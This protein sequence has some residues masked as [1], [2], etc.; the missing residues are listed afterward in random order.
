M[1]VEETTLTQIVGVSRLRK[2]LN[3]REI[4]L[5]WAKEGKRDKSKW[6][7]KSIISLISLMP[8][9]MIYCR[10]VGVGSCEIKRERRMLRSENT[11]RHEYADANITTNHRAN[12]FG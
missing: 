5:T 11:S 7:E 12:Q 6:L 3:D 10:L 2:K 8:E 4:G 9:S 1:S